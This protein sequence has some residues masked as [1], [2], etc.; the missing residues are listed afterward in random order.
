MYIR[1]GRDF[2]EAV[3]LPRAGERNAVQELF[4]LLRKLIDIPSVTG[5][6]GRCGEFV[7]EWL[8][9]RGFAVERQP[10]TPGR[11]NVYAALGRPEVILSTHLDTVGPYF[12]SSE[13]EEWIRGRGACDAKGSLACQMIAAER[14]ARAGAHDFGLLFLVG[15]ETVSDGARTANELPRGSRYL[16][17]GEPTGNR[18]VAATRGILQLRLKTRGR[19]AHSAYPE[20]GESAIEKLLDLLAELRSMPLPTDPELGRTTMNIG[21]ISGGIASNVIPDAAEATLL[22][23]TVGEGAELMHTI[24]A[25]IGGRAECEFPRL[26]APVR[27]MRMEGFEADVVAFTTDVSNLAR[28][29][30]PL[31]VGPGSILVA[32][33]A[34]E[35]VAK[36]EL[37]RAIELYLR[38][39]RELKSRGETEG[40]SL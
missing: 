28:W 4:D 36:A 33:T 5:D 40:R 37:A 35:R 34:E 32:H 27:L 11:A 29:G 13:D 22:F 12:G 26:V 2:N 19:A 31:L 14:L 38:L 17:M 16:V 30:R 8:A 10:V 20:L 18:L 24:E 3:P 25:L 1:S 15:E 9:A 39:V 23:R 6:E 7:A 21:S